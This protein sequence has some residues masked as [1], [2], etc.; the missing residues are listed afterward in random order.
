LPCST[1]TDWTTLAR[2][3]DVQ[4]LHVTI[5]ARDELPVAASIRHDQ[6]DGTNRVLKRFALNFR[7][8]HPDLLLTLNWN[9]ELACLRRFALRA[10]FHSRHPGHALHL[11]AAGWLSR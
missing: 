2:R 5:D 4:L 8:G 6:T 9:D 11:A 3:R 1:G 10:F 7:V